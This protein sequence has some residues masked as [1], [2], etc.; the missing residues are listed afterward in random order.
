MNDFSRQKKYILKN[1]RISCFTLSI[2]LIFLVLCLLI[3]FRDIKTIWISLMP[4]V[5]VLISAYYMI[6]TTNLLQQ[7]SIIDLGKI[8]DIKISRS[9]ISFLT[10]S[11]TTPSNR[12]IQKYYGIKIIADK[13]KYYYLFGE[14]YS[15]SAEDIKKIQN[16]LHGEY[17]VQC[18]EGTSII[19]TIQNDP[20]FLRIKFG[21]FYD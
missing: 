4:F 6:T 16:K 2:G 5:V 7:F 21:S 17:T 10:V 8:C 15:Y 18:Y 11:E 1:R 9:K 19:K 3:T 13:R 14:C 12:I 20:Y